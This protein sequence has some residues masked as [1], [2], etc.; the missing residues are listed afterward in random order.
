MLDTDKVVALG[1]AIARVIGSDELVD[2]LGRDAIIEPQ[3]PNYMLVFWPGVM[4][5]D[6]ET[7]LE[8]Y[9]VAT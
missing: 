5:P 9:E 2:T 6:W 1:I 3:G 7:V 4:C 8:P